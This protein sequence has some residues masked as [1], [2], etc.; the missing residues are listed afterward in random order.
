MKLKESDLQGKTWSVN[1]V[2]LA[3]HSWYVVYNLVNV[4]IRILIRHNIKNV[5]NEQISDKIV[6]VVSSEAYENS[7]LTL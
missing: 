2:V 6:D 4:K 3:C 5:V 7:V 1:D